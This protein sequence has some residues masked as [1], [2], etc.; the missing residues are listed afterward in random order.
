MGLTRAVVSKPIGEA[1][2]CAKIRFRECK[3]VMID[4]IV[5]VQMLKQTV[6]KA[7]ISLVPNYVSGWT[8]CLNG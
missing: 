8:L 6:C 5:K 1:L 4:R 7:V 3:N 2:T